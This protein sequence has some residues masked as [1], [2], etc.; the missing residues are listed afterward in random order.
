[1]NPDTIL[2]LG[3]KAPFYGVLLDPQVYRE[4]STKMLEWN[5]FKA[6]E[7]DYLKAPPME[8][9]ILL[10]TSDWIAIISLSAL[11]GAALTHC[12]DVHCL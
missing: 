4:V 3:D 11:A 9:P 1:M 12:I 8:I 5:D 2:N 7:S 6:H 10:K